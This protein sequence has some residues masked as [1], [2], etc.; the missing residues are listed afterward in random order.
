VIFNPK[1]FLE[2]EKT[3]IKFFE[4][5][6]FSEIYFDKKDEFLKNFIKVLPK[7]IKKK[8]LN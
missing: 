2:F 8:S 5:N 4:N 7:E 6:K 1:E 3:W